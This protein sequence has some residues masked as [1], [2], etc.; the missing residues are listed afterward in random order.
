MTKKTPFQIEQAEG[1]HA[2]W[3]ETDPGTFLGKAERGA[4]LS[5]LSRRLEL[6][7]GTKEQGAGVPRGACSN[8]ASSSLHPFS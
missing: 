4:F 2:H 8:S 1:V 3:D 6:Q 7:P 5:N